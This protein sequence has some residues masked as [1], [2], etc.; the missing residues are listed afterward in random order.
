MKI[1]IGFRLIAINLA[2][3]FRGGERVQMQ[4][5]IVAVRIVAAC[6]SV[7]RKSSNILLAGI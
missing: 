4:F 7:R 5:A 6:I 1:F 3:K 2:K